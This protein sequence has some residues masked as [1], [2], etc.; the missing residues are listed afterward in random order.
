MPG[1]AARLRA[2]TATLEPRFFGGRGMRLERDRGAMILLSPAL[3]HHDMAE[4]DLGAVFDFDFC[5][6]H[7]GVAFLFPALLV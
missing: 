4:R 6:V 5:A 3:L 1:A 7:H 2:L